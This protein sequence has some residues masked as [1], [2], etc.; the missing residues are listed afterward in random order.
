[1]QQAN[2]IQRQIGQEL[3]PITFVSAQMHV[4][5]KELWPD[6]RDQTIFGIKVMQEIVGRLMEV[7]A[8]IRKQELVR[9]VGM[10]PPNRQQRRQQERQGRRR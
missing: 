1:M 6:E 7:G 10:S 5:I 8:E 3:E 4:L 2:E 9:G